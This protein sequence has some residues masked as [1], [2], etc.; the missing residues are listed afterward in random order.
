MVRDR[1]AIP[2][3]QFVAKQPEEDIGM[4][5]RKISLQNRESEK[6]QLANRPVTAKARLETNESLKEKVRVL[7]GNRPASGYTVCVYHG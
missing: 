6:I 1:T 5:D 7:I 2:E 4:P 3:L